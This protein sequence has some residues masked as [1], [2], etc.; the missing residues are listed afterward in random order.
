MSGERDQHLR[1]HAAKTK[2]ERRRQECRKRFHGYHCQR[3]DHCA[4]KDDSDG[5]PVFEQIAQRSQQ[6]QPAH[7]PQLRQCH[8][9]AGL[10][11]AYV[12]FLADDARERLRV[13]DVADRQPAAHCE[14]GHQRRRE[15]RRLGRGCLYPH[16]HELL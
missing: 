11:V 5:P 16:G 1:D 8:Y 2:R 3:R 10:R 15:R 7:I 6:E 9:G 13:I 12:K 4:R 14:S